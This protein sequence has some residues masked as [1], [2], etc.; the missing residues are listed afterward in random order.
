MS[1]TLE[2]PENVYAA[3]VEAAQADGVS[4]MEWIKG[5]L[6]RFAAKTRTD[7][8]RSHSPDR[9]LRHAGAIDIG[10]PTGTDNAQID[11]DLG[12]EY[13]SHGKTP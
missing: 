2:L 10:R 12:C 7:L 5:K 8:E 3:L 1:Q 11:A 9:L 13:G 6:P 4:P